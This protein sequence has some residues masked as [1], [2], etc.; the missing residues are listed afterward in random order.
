MHASWRA[1]RRRANRSRNPGIPSS[2]TIQRH[3]WTIVR[4]NKVQILQMLNAKQNLRGSKRMAS[5]FI[6]RRIERGNRVWRSI[7]LVQWEMG[8]EMGNL[9]LQLTAHDRFKGGCSPTRGVIEWDSLHSESLSLEFNTNRAVRLK[10]QSQWNCLT[11][12]A[13]SLVKSKTEK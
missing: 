5:Q 3:M 7:D 13:I 8:M 11:T 1:N 4:R 9:V 12:S 2:R 10:V 6:V